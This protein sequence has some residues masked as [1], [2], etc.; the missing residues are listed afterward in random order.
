MELGAQI[1]LNRLKQFSLTIPS[2][3]YQLQAIVV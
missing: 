1:F 2:H 3:K